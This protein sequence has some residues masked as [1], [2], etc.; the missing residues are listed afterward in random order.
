MDVKG[1]LQFKLVG[2]VSYK[3]VNVILIFVEII[4]NGLAESLINFQGQKVIL[5]DPVQH[6]DSFL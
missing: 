3:L 1:Y 4:F 2:Q 6:L 5:I